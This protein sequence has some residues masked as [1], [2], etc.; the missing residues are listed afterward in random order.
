[1]LFRSLEVALSNV[2]LTGAATTQV[3]IIGDEFGNTLIHDDLTFRENGVQV[4][5]GRYKHIRAI[6][7]NNFADNMYG[8]KKYA[9]DDAYGWV[10]ECTIRE[11]QAMEV[12]CDHIVA[13]QTAQ[14]NKFFEA[15][16]PANPYDTLA[17]MLQTA[18]G[19]DK[20]VD[21]MDIGLVSFAKRELV[22]TEDRKSVV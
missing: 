21:D 10:G 2:S 14:P 1:M 4:T 8:S 11:A 15:F 3:C 22:A 19:P 9:L 20:S 5:R 6:L 13:S 7:F 17:S 12:S 18:I 16:H